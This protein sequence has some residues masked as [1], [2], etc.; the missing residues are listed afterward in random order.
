[1]GRRRSVGIKCSQCTTSNQS[2]KV[3][4]KG[5]DVIGTVLALQLQDIVQSCKDLDRTGRTVCGLASQMRMD[6]KL[7]K[8]HID[9]LFALF[10]VLKGGM[11]RLVVRQGKNF[12]FVSWNGGKVTSILCATK[13]CF[14][15]L[16]QQFSCGCCKAL[17][18]GR[19]LG[20]QVGCALLPD[21]AREA[22]RDPRKP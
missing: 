13:Q 18:G 20:S 7:D 2:M 6:S 22:R 11:E 16:L 19:Q 5:C 9:K 3:A 10:W 1:M 8:V 14:C 17:G 12:V 4:H 15:L 21:S